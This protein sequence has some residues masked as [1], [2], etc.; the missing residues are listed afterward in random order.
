VE[1]NYALFEL[2]ILNDIHKITIVLS[3]NNVITYIIEDG[4]ILKIK[5]NDYENYLNSNNIC[6]NLQLIDD[7]QYPST[8]E[9]YYYK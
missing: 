1:F 7:K 4:K 6:I 9:I 3:I 8:V 5:N 2:Y